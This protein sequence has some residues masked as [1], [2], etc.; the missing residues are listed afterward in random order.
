MGLTTTRIEVFIDEPD[1]L[2]ERAAQAGA[3]TWNRSA[4]T[5]RRGGR[6]VR[7]ALPIHLVI[8]GRWAT[9]PHCNG[10]PGRRRS[11]PAGLRWSRCG[12]EHR[13]G[14]GR[15]R[16]G[17]VERRRCGPPATTRGCRPC[18]TRT[19]RALVLAVPPERPA[20]SPEVDA[21]ALAATT[22]AV[23]CLAPTPTTTAPKGWKSPG[24]HH[25]RRG[26]ATPPRRPRR[27]HRAPP[28]VGP[29]NRPQPER[30]T[31]VIGAAPQCINAMTI[32]RPQGSAIATMLGVARR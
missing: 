9:G 4:R 31:G 18:R 20:A 6:T 8:V 25:L 27:G 32:L 28:V 17:A 7:A 10:F 15:Q 2:I 1:E 21:A 23:T 14:R 3:H 13:F 29:S 5:T 12:D 30:Q 22:N 11:E 16:W 26:L 19:H 24:L